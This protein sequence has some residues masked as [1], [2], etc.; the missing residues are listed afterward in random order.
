MN[1]PVDAMTLINQG[2]TAVAKH[3]ADGRLDLADME[4]Q[5][6]YRMFPNL[7]QV[8]HLRGVIAHK[9]KRYNEGIYYMETSI[10]MLPSNF[11]F[12]RN[13]TDAYK[14]AGRLDEAL[15]TARMAVE[16]APFDYV[17]NFNLAVVHMERNEYT[18]TFL[19]LDRAE[20]IKKTAD[21]QFC[22]AEVNLLLGNYKE[23]W[24]LY[25]HRFDIQGGKASIPGALANTP[26]WTGQVPK[27]GQKY[28]ILIISDQGYGDNIQF[29]RYVKSFHEKYPYLDLVMGCTQELTWLYKQFDFF[30][31]IGNSVDKLGEFDYY[32]PVSSLPLYLWDGVENMTPPVHVPIPVDALARWAANVKTISKDKKLKIGLAWAG[33][34]AHK[35]DA[36]RSMPLE[37]LKPFF[38]DEELDIFSL[39]KE[40]AN[41]QIAAYD[42]F[43]CN[44]CDCSMGLNTWEDTAAL[45]SQ[46]DLVLTVDTSIAHLAGSMGVRT[47]MLIPTA[48]DWRWGLNTDKTPWYPSITIFRQQSPRNWADPV[49]RAYEETRKIIASSSQ[50]EVKEAPQEAEPSP[51]FIPPQA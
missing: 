2:L 31:D 26:V 7:P 34:A 32:L 15:H 22:R 36:K 25:E 42:N 21:I 51:A 20:A 43:K 12:F 10:K 6:L 4:I 19:A 5:K 49:M 45:I 16:M 48:P 29:S 50:E 1:Q 3:E 44:M 41:A 47:F 46:V 17:A 13:I 11:T 27:E 33:R 28:T 39:Q 38:D 8:V 14:T 37:A 18:D 24:P 9:R 23:G 40:P 35:N 30:K